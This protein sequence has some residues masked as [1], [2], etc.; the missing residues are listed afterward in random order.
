M[1]FRENER[2]LSLLMNAI[3]SDLAPH[4]DGSLVRATLG[5]E[6]WAF[7]PVWAGEGLPADARRVRNEIV[8]GLSAAREP[9]TPV[10]MARH[11]SSGARKFLDEE[12][13][14][15]ADATGH[16]Q[17]VVPGRLYI[18][19]LD[20]TRARPATTF[21]WSAAADAI[22][23]TLLISRLRN[24]ADRPVDRLSTIAEISGVSPAHAARILRQFDDLGYTAKIGAERGSSAA[25]EFGAP[26][27]MLSDWAGHYATAGGQEPLAEFHVPWREPQ[28]SISMLAETLHAQDWALTGEAGADLI[29][30]HLTSVPAVDVY[31]GEDQL[32]D[33][34][35]LLARQAQVTEVH[36]GGR[37]RVREAAPHVIRL[38]N[39]VRD[40]YVASPVRVYAD[41]LR[42][43]GRSAE[44]AEFLRE[45]AIGF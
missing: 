29:A 35:R 31:V 36:T 7:H 41:L 12:G 14:S 28:R 33:A 24:G 40:A 21:R 13:L 18:S 27:R 20:P 8:H 39:E 17:L 34:S 42:H 37:I 2:A 10:V 15:W 32:R 3:P 9:A 38:R 16:A 25:R 5:H 26:G 6:A 43:R 11:L 45:V 30:P 22:A 4:R 44:A 23:E 19:R 1:A